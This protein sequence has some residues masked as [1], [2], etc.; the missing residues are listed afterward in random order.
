MDTLVGKAIVMFGI[1][2][3]FRT[4]E[5]FPPLYPPGNSGVYGQNLPYRIFPQGKDVLPCKGQVIG[6]FPPYKPPFAVLLDGVG[7]SDK[8]IAGK[9]ILP[10][11]DPQDGLEIGQGDK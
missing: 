4:K 11:I 2:K 8:A 1:N 10:V 3:V 5:G 7:G 9:S 6:V